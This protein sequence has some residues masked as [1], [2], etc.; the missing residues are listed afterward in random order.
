MK[1]V[2]NE[3]GKA[4]YSEN[5]NFLFRYKDGFFMRWGKT[6]RDD[7]QFSPYGPEL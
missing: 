2:E 6:T 1:I 4:L 7:P 3:I 5:Y